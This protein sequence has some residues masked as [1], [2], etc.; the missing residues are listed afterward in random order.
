[1]GGIVAVTGGAD[2]AVDDDRVDARRPLGPQIVRE[3]DGVAGEAEQFLLGNAET[4]RPREA[5]P[6][7]VGVEHVTGAGTLGHAE[8]ALEVGLHLLARRRIVHEYERGEGGRLEPLD[9]KHPGFE[10]TVGEIGLRG[11]QEF[12]YIVHD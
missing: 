12:R 5:S 6:L 3:A 11:I 2:D 9:E 7:G 1:M 10:P 4:L 8:E